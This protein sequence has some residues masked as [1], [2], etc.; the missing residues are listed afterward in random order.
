MDQYQLQR[1]VLQDIPAIEKK[2]RGQKKDYRF[3]I[4]VSK[5]YFPGAAAYTL[6]NPLVYHRPGSNGISEVSYFYSVPDK[7][8]RLIEYSY[9]K[10]AADSAL[11]KQFFAANDAYFT[12]WFKA[13]GSLS[14]EV[15]DNWWQQQQVWENDALHVKQFIVIGAD[16]YRVRVLVSWKR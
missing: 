12:N 16:T 13:P 11:L 15:H 14:S 4:T 7:V 9:D 8:V 3:T 5:T 1:P 6:A 10:S 2:L